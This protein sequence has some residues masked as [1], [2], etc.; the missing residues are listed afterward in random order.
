MRPI[1]RYSTRPGQQGFT[2]V[3]AILVIVITGILFASVAMF[4]RLPVEGAVSTTRRAGLADIADTALQRLRRD[5]RTA[6]PNSVRVNPAG[7]HVEFLPV[8]AGGRYCAEPD[9]GGTCSNAAGSGTDALD[10]Y[11]TDSSFE[12]IGPLLH[13]SSFSAS[14]TWLAVYNL[15]IPGA[16]AYNLQSMTPITSVS[17]GSPR[18][19][20]FGPHQFPF[21]SPDSRFHIVSAPV[22]YACSAGLSGQDGSG[23]LLRYTGYPL[24][25]SQPTT[26]AGIPARRLA[27]Y[28][29]D[30]RFDYTPASID[31]DGL[32]TLTLRVQQQGETVSLTHAIQISNT[33]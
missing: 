7:T 24:Q 2:L 5:L 15:G 26:F 20:N 29:A 21:A 17:A 18:I 11:Q 30:C 28:L 12:V 16:D 27:S 6:L 1:D 19:I 23:S 22:S 31:R 4:L 8:V 14:N 32:L 13:G 9:S 25:A 3:E 33:P 10:F